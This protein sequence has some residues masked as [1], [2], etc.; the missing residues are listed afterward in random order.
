M[1]TRGCCCVE[2][3][4]RNDVGSTGLCLVQSGR[5]AQRLFVELFSFDV[6]KDLVEPFLQIVR[7]RYDCS[8]LPRLCVQADVCPT[9]THWG[10]EQ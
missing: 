1:D 5:A 4:E 9:H 8:C 7:T 3:N 6:R 2:F 10:R